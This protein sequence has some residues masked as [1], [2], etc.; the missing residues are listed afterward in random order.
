MVALKNSFNAVREEI[1]TALLPAFQALIGIL[2]GFAD[3]V[4]NNTDLVLTLGITLA[5]MTGTIVALSIAMKVLAV[6]TALAAVKLTAFG[7]ALTATGIGAIV[8]VIGLLVA[9]FVQ[10]MIHSEKARNVMKTLIN[11]TI[12][13][14][15]MLVNAVIGV[16]NSFISWGNVFNGVFRALGINIGNMNQIA[17]VAFGRVGDSAHAAAAGVATI[18]GH[19]RELQTLLPATSNLVPTLFTVAQATDMVAK[20]DK[21]V[22]DLRAA[23]LKGGTSIDALND[24]IKEQ[25]D[26]QKLLATLTGQSGRQTAGAA[27]ATAEAVKPFEAYTKV[28]KDAQGASKS[29]ES[30]QRRVKDTQKSLTEANKDLADAQQALLDAQKAGSPAEIADAQRAVAA[31]ERGVTRGKFAQEQS[32]FAV[33][34][35][36]RKLR[37][38]REKGGATAQ[39]IREAEIALDEAKL[40]VVDHEDDQIDSTRKLEEARRNLRIATQGLK[41]G[42]K[43]LVPIQDAVTRAHEAQTKAAEQAK[44]AIDDQTEAV[45]KYK[46]ALDELATAIINFPKVAARVGQPDLI[47]LTPPSAEAFNRNAGGG[48]MMMGDTVVNVYSTIADAD[49]PEKLVDALRTYNRN[50]GPLNVQILSGQRTCSTSAT[51]AC[52]WMLVSSRMRSHWIRPRWMGLMCWMGQPSSLM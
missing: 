44:D 39:E 5:V 24:A 20:A 16:I 38:I 11:I 42:D 49:L 7:V 6:F 43:E 8:V 46:A 36:E 32:L 1:G 51:M 25:G 4:A 47:P 29:Y 2:Q 3:F 40:R 48:Q 31:A 12:A 52:S 19:L 34:D 35:A 26:A 13:G 30:T 14:F 18:N 9:G 50:Q 37:E 33:A 28:L 17:P 45:N 41:E 23:A 21:K 15:E 22:S 27:K 10:L